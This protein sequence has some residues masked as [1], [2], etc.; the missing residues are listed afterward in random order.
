MLNAYSIF[1]I[2]VV[3]GGFMGALMVGELVL[4]GLDRLY[5]YFRERM[6]P[7]EQA[8]HNPPR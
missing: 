6:T 4:T 8:R 1:Y 3:V 2:L 5:R 7:H